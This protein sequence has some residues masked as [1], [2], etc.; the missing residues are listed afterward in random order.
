M[1]TVLETPGS[2]SYA[3]WGDRAGGYF[4]Q[5]FVALGPVLDE[6]Q[7]GV[8]DWY[9]GI[10]D[11]KVVITTFVDGHPGEVVG[12]SDLIVVSVPS[13]QTVNFSG[14]TLIEGQSYAFL[15]DTSYG[16][17]STGL[18]AIG[19]NF[20]PDFYLDG[21]LFYSTAELP[22]GASDLSSAPIKPGADMAFR[23]VFSDHAQTITVNG[24]AAADTFVAQT[25]DNYVYS[26]LGGNDT[27]VTLGGADTVRGGSGSDTISTGKENDTIIYSGTGEGY[28][29]VDGGPGIDRFGTDSIIAGSN[30]TRIGLRAIKDI[31]IISANGFSNVSIVG[32]GFAENLDLSRTKLIGITEINLNGGNDTLIGSLGDDTI[33]G[34][35][36]NDKLFGYEG[37]DTFLFSGNSGY[38]TID[39]GSG[40]D[41]VRQALPTLF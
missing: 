35:G 16:V 31:E 40:K 19:I 6:L 32:S 4:G 23:L 18:G 7:F 13:I 9:G 8:D 21:T 34:G 3:G 39:G 26:G 22:S 36:G 27:I 1:R 25:D 33:I 10:T 24:S 29:S 12:S 37:S 28:D 17:Y 15:L 11:Y 41:K 14:I 30:G 20:Y 2:F 38:D 5:S